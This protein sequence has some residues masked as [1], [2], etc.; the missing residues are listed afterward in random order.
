MKT[1]K[2][3]IKK[4]ECEDACPIPLKLIPNVE[5]RIEKISYDEK[6]EVATIVYNEKLLSE[7]QLKDKLKEVGYVVKK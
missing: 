4:E 2:L 1:I 5:K 6:T 3:W 7:K